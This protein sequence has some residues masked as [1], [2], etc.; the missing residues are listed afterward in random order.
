MKY[1]KDKDVA[2]HLRNY[3]K[4]IEAE[5]A[6]ASRPGQMASLESIAEQLLELAEFLEED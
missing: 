1:M 5:A 2:R 6:T 4:R 3:A